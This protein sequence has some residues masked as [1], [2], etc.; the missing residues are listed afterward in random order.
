MKATSFSGGPPDWLAPD[1]SD[2]RISA[3]A[4]LDNVK[5]IEV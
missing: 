4:A 2:T 1:E 3:E 5:G